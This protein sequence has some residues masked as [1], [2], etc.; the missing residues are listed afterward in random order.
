VARFRD[1]LPQL[2]DSLFL[3]DSGLE[4]TL[5]FLDGFELPHFAS[6]TLLRD[7]AGRRHLDEY[8]LEHM[9]VAAAAGA[10]FILESATWRSSPDWGDLLGYS[11]PELAEANRRAIDTLVELRE[12][13][14]FDGDVVVSGCIGPRTDGYSRGTRMTAEQARDYHAEQ[15]QTFAATEADM[16][17]AMTITYPDEAV[18]IVLA[19]LEAELPVAI[20]FTLET[21]GVLPDGT[22]LGAAI[23]RVDEATGAAAAY[24][25]INCAHPTHFAHVLDPS[26]ASTQRLRGLRANASRRSHAEL[27]EAAALDAGDPSELGAEY[28]ELRELFPNL[29]VLGGCCGTDVRHVRAIADAVVAR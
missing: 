20:S 16:A 27:D 19:A 7:D 13:L 3:T 21:D 15:V 1:S 5:I 14:D 10:G 9:Q 11:R 29:T 22:S 6:I 25:G 12:G 26:A 8:F 24:F 2:R 28:A 23:K 17:H 4:T 18:G